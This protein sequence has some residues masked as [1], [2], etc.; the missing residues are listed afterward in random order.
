MATVLKIDEFDIG[1]DM[2]VRRLGFG[3]MRLTGHGIW[4]PPQDVP[5]AQA[6]LRRVVD[7]GINFVDT[8]DVY[9]PGDNERLIRDALGPYPAGLVIGTK[10]GMTRSG[11][12]TPDNH[13]IGIDNSETHLRHAVEESLRDLGVER[14]DLFQLHR[15]DPMVPI[16][17]TMAVLGRLRAEGLI[18]HIGLSAVSVDQIERARSVVE[19]ATVQNEYNLVTRKHEDVLEYCERHDIG[20]IPFYPRKIGKFAESK[21]LQAIATR[22]D[23]TPSVI[24][25]AWLFKRSPAIIAIPGTSS[26]EHLNENVTACGVRLSP[27]DMAALDALST[28]RE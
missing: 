18:R 13:G 3:A 14:I 16:E 24:A 19:V 5:A 22:E 21:A 10:G 17:D 23:V 11:P 2:P 7:L 1:G 27:A 9:G 25:L 8:A 15:A 20:F 4:G 28:P 26:V 6:V 12:A